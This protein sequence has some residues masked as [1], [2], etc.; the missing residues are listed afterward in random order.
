MH[1][2]WLFNPLW[3]PAFWTFSRTFVS[4]FES[5]RIFSNFR[6]LNST[7]FSESSEF[8]NFQ[9]FRT[10]GKTSFRNYQTFF[11]KYRTFSELFQTFWPKNRVFCPK[12]SNFTS[13]F[14][15]FWIITEFFT[16]LEFRTFFRTFTRKF[17][18]F[19]NSVFFRKI[20]GL[21]K[22]NIS[23]TRENEKFGNFRLT[24]GLTFDNIFSY[25]KYISIT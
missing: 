23:E 1:I 2:I 25:L 22:P 18:E 6:S 13:F 10:F 11:R 12:T 5:E 19:E 20:S 8:P 7:S 3:G 17:R 14:Q 21:R 16:E 15:N 24:R 9:N 4:V